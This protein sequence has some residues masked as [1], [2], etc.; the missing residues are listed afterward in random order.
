MN[1]REN[2]HEV[3]FPNIY[4]VD[5]V[6]CELNTSLTFL[7]ISRRQIFFLMI[8]LREFKSGWYFTTKG[9]P[10]LLVFFLLVSLILNL[11]FLIS[12]CTRFSGYSLFT[13]HDLI[14][15]LFS[16]KVTLVRT[17]STNAQS[18]TKNGMFSM[19]RMNW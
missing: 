7:F 12:E 8:S 9:T 17:Q 19:V 1:A 10:F 16:S 5:N 11:T 14:F 18:L 4:I 3:R 6:G 2:M 15:S 13:N